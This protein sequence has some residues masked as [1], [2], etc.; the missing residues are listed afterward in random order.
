MRDGAHVGP[1]THEIF[2]R[3]F[4]VE[5]GVE[6]WDTPSGYIRRRL[7][8][9]PELPKK[10]D[11]WRI[12]DTGNRAG[13]GGVV[14][15]AYGFKD[16]PDAE[17]LLLGF[18]SGKEYGAVGVG[19]QGNVLQW[20]YAAPPAKMSEMGRR[21]FINCICYI[22]KF[23]G[24]LPLVRRSGYPREH[25]LRLGALITRL[26]DKDFFSS[27]FAPE[28]QERFRDDPD[29]LVKYYLDDF[30]LIYREK[31]FDID[32]DLKSLGIQSNREI[33]TLDRLIELL[34]DRKHAD[35]ARTLLHRY[36]DQTFS[37]SPPWRHWLDTNRGRIFFSDFGGY[38]FF[39]I[40]K[41]YLKQDA[42]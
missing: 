41:G 1:M 16:S 6:S 9:E 15:R 25:A 37:S 21:L 8:H 20:G 31:F 3:P 22:S 17:A 33:K 23:D 7:P 14:A 32:K 29:G 27:T 4:T 42:L 36:T 5:S 39:V 13:S 18:N 19:R 12:Q 10:M 35:T 30:E 11:I 28:L 38:K 26:K 40:P 2:H 34:D 24:K